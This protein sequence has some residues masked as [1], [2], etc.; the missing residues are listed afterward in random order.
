MAC[1]SAAWFVRYT[2]TNP[3]CLMTKKKLLAK[4]KKNSNISTFSANDQFALL[5]CYNI[6]RAGAYLAAGVGIRMIL[7]LQTVIQLSPELLRRENARYLLEAWRVR[8]GL[9]GLCGVALACRS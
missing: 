6:L 3:D 2:S 5:H 9:D 7:P 1:H 8:R 4:Q